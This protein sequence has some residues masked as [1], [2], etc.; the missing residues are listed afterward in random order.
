MT[1]PRVDSSAWCAS[2]IACDGPTLPMQS[3]ERGERG[4]R[5]ER[6]LRSVT[7]AVDHARSASDPPTVHLRPAVAGD[8]LAAHRHQRAPT[9][10]TAP[11]GAAQ[12]LLEHAHE[13]AGAQAGHAVDVEQRSG[14]PDACPGRGPGCRR[15]RSRPGTTASTLAMPGPLSSAT[16]SRPPAPAVARAW[17]R[18]TVPLT[19][20]LQ[21]VGAELG[22]DQRGLVDELLAS[23]RREWPI[24][25]TARRTSATRLG[26][27]TS[28]VV[29]I[30]TMRTC[31]PAPGDEVISN[32]LTRRLAPP[33]PSPRLLR[34][35]EAV[36]AS[37]ATCR[38]CRGPCRRSRRCRPTR[39]FAC[40][41]GDR[42]RRRRRHGPACCAPAR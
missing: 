42:H 15:W 9:S 14:A 35:G 5:R 32:S 19:G 40:D 13:D 6:G 26:S 18:V 4:L 1:A 10:R 28:I 30:A 31:V 34:G 17:P 21:D 41:F 29:S 39:P 33:R 23:G 11:L 22:R 2:L 16:M 8:V 24:T 12:L 36:A 27:P 37:P 3:L 25:A 38:R 20:V 7:Q